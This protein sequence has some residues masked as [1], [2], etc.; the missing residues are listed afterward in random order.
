MC[1]DVSFDLSYNRITI[2]AYHESQQVKY[3][4]E[5]SFNLQN[6]YG[7]IKKDDRLGIQVRIKICSA[8]PL[9]D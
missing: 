7:F 6:S 5:Y 8:I 1:K 3:K 2:R 9:V 4:I